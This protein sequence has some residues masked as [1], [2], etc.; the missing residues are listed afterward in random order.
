MISLFKNLYNYYEKFIFELESIY[1]NS[2]INADSDTE[3]DNTSEIDCEIKIKPDTKFVDKPEP[4][5]EPEP[6]T[7]KSYDLNIE[8]DMNTINEDHLC[9]PIHKNIN[10]TTDDNINILRQRYVTFENN[11][12]DNIN[13]N[14]DNINDIL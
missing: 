13:S 4:E 3:P 10:N 14:I 12:V 5:P 1:S 11:N 7:P 8:V 9:T 6:T 2:D